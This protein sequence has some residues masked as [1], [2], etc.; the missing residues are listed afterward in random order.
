MSM[1][2]FLFFISIVVFSKMP[3]SQSR[4][5][6][7]IFETQSITYNASDDPGICMEAVE[8][9]IVINE[10]NKTYFFSMP[11]QVYEDFNIKLK[12]KIVSVTVDFFNEADYYNGVVGNVVKIEFE[13]IPFYSFH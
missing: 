13:D 4:T 5:F 9:G 2:V 3:F 11:Y 12:G 6:T 1:K 10:G 8:Y 7:G